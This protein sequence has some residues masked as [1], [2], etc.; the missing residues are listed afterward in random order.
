MTDKEYPE[1][2]EG[3]WD[4]LDAGRTAR[5]FD[6]PA[7]PGKEAPSRIANRVIFTCGACHW[8]IEKHGDTW[9]HLGQS[10]R[11][12]APIG[13]GTQ[14]HDR[15]KTQL[16]RGTKGHRSRFSHASIRRAGETGSEPTE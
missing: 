12:T 16:I 5:K 1:M 9:R 2:F 3:E 15:G 4:D 6:H 11:S 14:E 10:R 13:S 7:H 8:Q